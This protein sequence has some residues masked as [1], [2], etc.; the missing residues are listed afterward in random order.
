MTTMSREKEVA[1]SAAAG[2]NG[3]ALI[4]ND[5]LL[6]LYTAMLKCRLLDERLRLVVKQ[7]DL[8]AANF[9]AAGQEAAIV[10]AAFDLL[11]EDTFISRHCDLLPC[12]LQGL[13]LERLLASVFEHSTTSPKSDPLTLATHAAMANQGSKTGRIAVAILP[14][15][16]APLKPRQRALSFASLHGLPMVVVS[17][18]KSIPA[19]S[20]TREFPAI[21]VDGNDVV[22]VYRVASEAISHAR[23]G[24]GP[25]LIECI[26]G[27]ANDPILN[28]ENYLTRKGLFTRNL[29]PH[30]VAGFNKELDAAL[31]RTQ[32]SLLLK[33]VEE[34][35]RP[36]AQ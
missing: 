12:L 28:M 16:V 20:K 24:S 5:K 36:F 17:W 35:T 23:K 7:E 27:K 9:T 1:G 30:L 2:E 14:S 29:K 13:P 18:K 34:V 10:G 15:A 8:P 3:F 31:K 4:S 19:R 25:T 26:G 32:E 6:Q 22:A 11:P 33:R 21:T